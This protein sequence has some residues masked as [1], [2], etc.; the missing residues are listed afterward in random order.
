MPVDRSRDRKCENVKYAA[1]QKKKLT[2]DE[3]FSSVEF[4]IQT[5]SFVRQ[6]TVYPDLVVHLASDN[7]L[8]LT[9]DLIKQCRTNL[10]LKQLMSYD[11]AFLLGDFYVSILIARNT[12]LADD[13]IFP[14]AFLIH[15]KKYHKAVVVNLF[16]MRATLMQLLIG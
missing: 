7:V 9:K 16:C 3:F 12:R 8:T 14:V 15:T 10:S 4:A 6:F 11:T 5:D 13:P 1:S 2:N